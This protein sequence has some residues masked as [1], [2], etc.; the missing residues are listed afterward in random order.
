MGHV[1][2]EARCVLQTPVLF[3][4]D[5]PP[6]C[7]FQSRVESPGPQVLIREAK[8]L[9]SFLLSCLGLL[10]SK[11]SR[12]GQDGD[13]DLVTV[14]WQ[15]WGSNSILFSQALLFSDSQCPSLLSTTASSASLSPWLLFQRTQQ[16][17]GKQKFLWAEAGV[18]VQSC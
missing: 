5:L 13:G 1:H 17:H 18:M 2:P 6:T 4:T 16:P 8:G 12:F 15:N 10:S 14:T 7:L 3:Q 9:Q 11:L